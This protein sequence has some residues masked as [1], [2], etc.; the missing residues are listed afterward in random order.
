M[1]PQK[2][3]PL[4]H[5]YS[6]NNY[7]AL[8]LYVATIIQ[9]PFVFSKVAYSP[10]EE[11]FTNANTLPLI[12]VS[13]SPSQDKYIASESNKK[14]NCHIPFEADARIQCKRSSLSLENSRKSNSSPVNRYFLYPGTYLSEPIE[15]KT[16]NRSKCILRSGDEFVDI[17]D[18]LQIMPIAQKMGSKFYIIDQPS[19]DHK[20]YKLNAILGFPHVLIELNKRGNTVIHCYVLDF[21]NYTYEAEMREKISNAIEESK[22]RCK[23]MKQFVIRN[24]RIK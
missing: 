12:E 22:E 24:R 8:T 14:N 9:A 11:H 20:K 3:L 10:R 17:V 18:P 7:A 6:C 21:S 13:Y 19:V 1:N 2:I 15:C 23:V 16:L 4:N 5:L